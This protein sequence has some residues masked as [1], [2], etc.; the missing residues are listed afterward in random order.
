MEY[1]LFVQKV[2][3]D[4]KDKYIE[5]HKNCPLSLLKEIRDAGIDQEMIWIL[6]DLLIIYVIAKD[7]EKSMDRLAKKDIFQRWLEIM[8][9]LLSEVQDYSEKGK[10]RKLDKIFDLEKQLKNKA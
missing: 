5:Y 4:K 2:K 1:I 7:F 10:I 3:K 8:R 6:D 9:P